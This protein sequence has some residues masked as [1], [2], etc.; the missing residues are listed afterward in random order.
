MALRRE[1][2][3]VAEMRRALPPGGEPPEDYVF[4]RTAAHGRP[5]QVRL[6]ELFEGRPSIVLYSYMYGPERDVPCNGC[7]HLLD[8]IDGAAPWPTASITSSAALSPGSSLCGS[9]R[10]EE[11]TSELQ[12]LMR[13]SYAVF[14]LKKKKNI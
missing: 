11:H 8:A 4:E 2:E 7:T 10:S 5:E 3:R 14:R 6:S 12:S 13:T 9:N 1:L